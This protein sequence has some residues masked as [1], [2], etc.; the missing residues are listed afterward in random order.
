VYQ[1]WTLG[2]V[3]DSRRACWLWKMNLCHHG[4]IEDFP[5]RLGRFGSRGA[6]IR[7]YPTGKLGHLAGDLVSEPSCVWLFS[8]NVDTSKERDRY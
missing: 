8:S 1:R 5:G 2:K 6:L 4:R 7:K 3:P